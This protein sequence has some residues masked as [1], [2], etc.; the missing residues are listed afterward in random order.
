MYYTSLL[1]LPEPP[2]SPVLVMK[3]ESVRGSSRET[4]C[5]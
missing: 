2:A 1:P 5:K 3:K 4:I